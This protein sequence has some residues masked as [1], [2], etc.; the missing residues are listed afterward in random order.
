MIAAAAV[1]LC[2]AAQAESC[3]LLSIVSVPAIQTKREEKEG[4]REILRKIYGEKEKE[5]ER[6]LYAC[7]I[8]IYRERNRGSDRNT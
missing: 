5:M 1:V 6:E 2:S 7:E 4:E 8:Y 3:L